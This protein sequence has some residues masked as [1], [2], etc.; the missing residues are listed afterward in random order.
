MTGVA[1]AASSVAG[2]RVPADTGY[3]S[4]AETGAAA[5][6]ARAAAAAGGG[7]GGGAKQWRLGR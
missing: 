6:R 2:I 1:P 4:G 7:G 5:T 3:I